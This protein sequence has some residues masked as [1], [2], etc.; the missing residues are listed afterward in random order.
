MGGELLQHLLI[1]YSLTKCNHYRSI[2]DTRNGIAN[3]REP[4]DE[5]T[6]GF[7]RALLDGVEIGQVTRP[8][9]SALEVGRE[10]AAQLWPGVEGSLGKIHESG[11]GRPH[12]GYREV[13]GHDSLILA[14]REDGGEV[15]LQELS[16]VDCTVILLW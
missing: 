6:Q 4:L 11:P 12:Q 5:G 9:I 14:C 8:S 15:D 7:P 2:G 10:L 16:R 1:P 13:V 3:L